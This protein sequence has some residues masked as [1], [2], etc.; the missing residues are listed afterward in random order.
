M[1]T[2]LNL[3]GRLG[4][5]SASHPWRSIAVWLIFVVVALATGMSIGTRSL[6][7]AQYGSGSSGAAQLTLAKEFSQPATEQV[8]VRSNALSA[9]QPEFR[10][11]VSEVIGNVSETGRAT[12]LRSPYASNGIGISADRHS[13]LVQFD[14][15]GGMKAYKYLAPIQAAV[16]TASKDHPKVSIG[17]TGDASIAKAG[18]QATGKDFKRAERMSVPLTLIVL[19]FTFGALVAAVLPLALALTAVAAATGLMAFASHLNAASDPTSS[20]IL[21]I[22]LAVGVDYSLFY[23]KREREERAAGANPDSALR[24][25]ASTSGRSVLISGVTVLIAMAGMFVSGSTVFYGI[26]WGSMLVVAVAVI[27][28]LTALPAIMSLLGDRIERGR[29]PGLGKLRRDG[30]SR[31]W[32]FVLER[33]L[34]RPAIAAFLSAGALLALAVPVLGMHTAS[35]AAGGLPSNVPAVAT[36]NRIQATFPG[37][38][39]PAL[40]VVQAKDVS[41]AAV[42]AAINSME[43]AAL[44]TG[45]M[46]QPIHEQINP[47]HTVAVVSI[48]LA[49]SGDDGVSTRALHTLRTD[50]IPATIG[51]VS[52][53][54]TRVAGQTAATVDFN[55]LMSQ[56][57]PLIFGFVLFLAF[58]L[59]LVSF[60][61]LVIA[62]KAIV[63]NLLSVGAAYGV[64]VWVF[65]DGHG[66]RLLHFHSSHSITSWLPLFM[67]VILFGL[68][69]DYHVFILSRIKEAR[70]RGAS[71]A[72]A[73]T[74]GIKTTAGTVTAAAIVMVM[75]FLTF[76]TLSQLEMKEAGIGLATAVLLDATLVRVVLLPAS[77]KLLGK[78]N[79]YLPAWLDWLPR[80]GHEA[81]IPP[82][83]FRMPARESLADAVPEHRPAE[84]VDA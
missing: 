43:R 16:A 25:A 35:P 57:M 45:Q 1:R 19:T 34:R 66:Q 15:V 63:L 76:A 36:Y 39:A 24:A 58:T 83:G 14:V 48:P 38:P 10:A 8:L 81:P 65:Q 61:S 26:A 69:M 7:M 13:A 55:N 11:A 40:V 22:G 84:L 77:M 4:R 62:L 59:L 75:V 23:L 80:L 53:T 31:A 70:D 32:G 82:A 46:N 12:D 49:G 30:D 72:D 50:V 67:F 54:T 44:A 71:T 68:S 5:W 2:H 79:W 27:G 29:I 56:R 42:Q 28:S 3:T 60:R 52:G 9:D 18:K 73:V 74:S 47:A 78:W 33:V 6:T 64:L 20:I 51:G 37:G 17:E 21:L 41:A